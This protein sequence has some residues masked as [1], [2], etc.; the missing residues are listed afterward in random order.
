MP[1]YAFKCSNCGEIFST[2]VPNCEARE[3]PQECPTCGSETGVYNEAETLHRSDVKFY[4]GDI[5]FLEQRNRGNPHW[6]GLTDTHGTREMRG[7]GSVGG[8]RVLPLAPPPTKGKKVTP[9]P[10]TTP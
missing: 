6:R 9:P 7:K 3:E 8:A 4:M 10:R 2:L 5:H 1:K